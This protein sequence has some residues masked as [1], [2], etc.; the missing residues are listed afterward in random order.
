MNFKKLQA[1]FGDRGED[2]RRKYVK[3]IAYCSQSQCIYWIPNPKHESFFSSDYDP[4][5]LWIRW[6][7]GKHTFFKK[8]EEIGD[9]VLWVQTL[10]EDGTPNLYAEVRDD[11]HLSGSPYSFTFAGTGNSLEPFIMIATGNGIKE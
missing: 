5:E 8:P 6:E 7:N 11:V 1:W 3:K 10:Q 2:L 9:R 4:N